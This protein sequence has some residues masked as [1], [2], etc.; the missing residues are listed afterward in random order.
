M[1]CRIFFFQFANQKYKGIK[2]HR[3]IILP[4]VFCECETWLLIL[5]KEHRVRVLEH[6]VL[7]GYFGLR[8]M[9]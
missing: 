5:R 3:T 4:Y 2:M 1:R 6:R 9:R 7:R 8:G